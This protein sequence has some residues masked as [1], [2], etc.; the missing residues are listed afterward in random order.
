MYT[1]YELIIKHEESKIDNIFKHYKSFAQIFSR[2]KP[3]KITFTGLD[4]G[5]IKEIYEFEDNQ[6]GNKLMSRVRALA[7]KNIKHSGYDSLEWF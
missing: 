5:L 6:Q 2:L 1:C 3:K 7:Y 4:V